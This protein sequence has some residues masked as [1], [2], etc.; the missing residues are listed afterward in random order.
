MDDFDDAL[1]AVATRMKAAIRDV[2]VLTCRLELPFPELERKGF[3]ICLKVM[4]SSALGA[5]HGPGIS[6]VAW[7]RSA[8][9]NRSLLPAR[10]QAAK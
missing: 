8:S 2:D 6:V 4:G 7:E 10:S 1:P 3:S 5:V 9:D